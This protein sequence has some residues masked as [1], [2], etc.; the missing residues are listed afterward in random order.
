VFGVRPVDAYG[1]D[2]SPAVR[3]VDLNRATQ[4]QLVEELG[5]TA[6]V[7]GALIAARKQRPVGGLSDLLAVKGLAAEQA[8]AIAHRAFFAEEEAFHVTDVRPSGRALLSGKPFALRISY[9]NP[10]GGRIAVAAVTVLWAGEPFVVET[11]PPAGA[12]ATGTVEVKFDSRRTLPVGPA[13]FQVALYRADGAQ[14]SFRK[15]FYVLPSNPLSLSLSPGGATVTGTWSARGDFHPENDTFLTECTVTIANGDAG[16]VSMNRRVDWSFWDGGVGTGR[17]VESGS[18]NWGGSISVPGFGTWQGGVW[19]SSPRGSGIYET[20]KRKEDMAINIEMTAADG[21]QISGQITCRVML[22]YGVNIIKVGDFGAQE[23]LDLY[24][25]VDQT[26]QI[27][28]ARDIT[29]R[30]IDRRII[31]NSLAGSFTVLNDDPEFRNLL[32]SWSVPNDF[33]D[34]YVVQQ[35]SWSTFNGMAGDIPGPASKG[36]DKD[37]VAGDKTGFTDA[38]GTARLDITTLGKLLGHEIGHYLGLSHVTNSGR[39]MLANTGVRGTTLI[40]DEYRTM[41]PHGFMVF[42]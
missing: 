35:F 23:H 9:R 24:A 26:R 6:R 17:L 30:G 29:F 28:E 11:R 39:L 19:F 37:G 42:L 22:A 41:F 4:K 34:V 27:Y 38:S 21:R 16:A 2:D 5:V 8:R 32:R 14:A 7:A 36:G 18:F 13:L 25:A 15:T 12:G 40:Y 20:F 3:F 10:E 33:I 1:V 31:N